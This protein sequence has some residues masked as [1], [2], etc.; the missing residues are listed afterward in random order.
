MESDDTVPA[1]TSVAGFRVV[2]LIGSGSLGSVYEATQPSVGRTVALRLI[3]KEHFRAP[4]D[5]ERFD[6]QQRDFAAIHHPRLV[7]TYEAGAW[8]G[9]RFVA[10]RFVRGL[11]LE[12][13]VADGSL[14][15]SG[16]DDLLEPISGALAAA[17]VAGLVHGRLNAR[18]VLIDEAGTAYLADFGLGRIGTP[19]QDRAA[20]TEVIAGAQRAAPLRGA[21]RLSTFQFMIGLGLVAT[22]IAVAVAIQSGDDPGSAQGTPAPALTPGADALGSAIGPGPLQSAG[23]GPDPGPNTPS[24][25]LAQSVIDGDE[26]VA[27][28]AGVVRAWAVR[29]ASGEIAL[30]VIGERSGEAFIRG[31]SQF[32]RVEGRPELFESNLRIEP[33]DLIGVSLGPATVIG[34][35][36]S[37]G[38][39]EVLRWEGGLA[40]I[41][42]LPDETLDGFEILVRADIEYG[43]RPD[44]PAALSGASASEA[45]SGE[46]LGSLVLEQAGP[47]LTRAVLVRVG[48][49]IAIDLLTGGTRT[50][51][52]PVDDVEVGGD[53]IE[54]RQN[55]GTE[56]SFCLRWSNG[57][58]T[59]PVF[60]EYVLSRDGRSLRTIG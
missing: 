16:P 48:Q 36:D 1:G 38:G 33:G 59:P 26:A 3:G 58:S 40:D 45:Q 30:Q 60:H 20:L 6:R 11:S 46:E 50:Y 52:V 29:G 43:S 19:D 32:E 17:H 13:R 49:T 24:C 54:L 5:V 15:A 55:C 31:F 2:R 21:R 44:R 37:P 18:N 53:L 51:R 27:R 14:R 25:T 35:R 7:P 28:R 39:S 42:D 10:M 12:D 56:S 22:G 41:S 4:S 57:V 34:T 9:G 8:E 47:E 23:C